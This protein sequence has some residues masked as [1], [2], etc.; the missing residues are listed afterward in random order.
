M[1]VKIDHQAIEVDRLPTLP[2]IA[3]EAIRLMEG[4]Q[5][6]F[7]SIADLLKN[8]QVLTSRILHYANSAYIGSRRISSIS[9]AVSII[10]FNTIRSIILSAS[11]FDF[12]SEKIDGEKEGLVKFWLHSIGVAATAEFLAERLG[13]S[14]P[15]EAYVAGL[16]HDLG[17]LICYTQFPEKF[18]KLCREIDAQGTFSTFGSLPLDIEKNILDTTH[19]EIGKIA[20]NRWQFPEILNKVM[21]LHHQPVVETIEPDAANLPKL[22]RFADVLCVTHNIGSSYF[23]SSETYSHE[24]HHFALERLLLHHHLTTED[25]QQIMSAVYERIKNIGNVLGF[26]D[27]NVYR[28]LVGSANASLGDISLDLEKTNRELTETNRILGAISEM[29]QKLKAGLSLQETAKVVIKAARD[30]F[31]T[32]R[33][34]CIIRNHATDAFIGQSFDNGT[35]HEVHVPTHIST[36]KQYDNEIVSD[37]E[38]EAVQRLERTTLELSKGADF[39]AGI[40]DIVAG[41]K[42]LATFFIADQKSHWQNEPILGELVVDFT[43]PNL[44]EGEGLKNLSENFKAIAVAAG[45][46]IERLLLEACLDRQNQELAEASRKMEESQRQLFHSHRLATVGQLAAGAAHEINNPLTIISLNIQIMERLLE[47]FKNNEE[48]K[49]RLDVIADQEKRISKIIQELMGFARPSQPKFTP[50]SIAEIAQKVLSVINDRVSM[51]KIKIDNRIKDLPPVMVD[52]LQIEQV[53]MNLLINANHAMPDGGKITLSAETRDGFAVTHVTDTGTGIS[54]ENLQRIF[55]PFFT[56]K[57]E[58]EG[59]G[60]GLAVCNSIIEHNGG[61]LRVRSKLKKGTT[62]SFSLPIDKGSRLREMKKALEKNKE[63]KASAA[64]E[65]CRILII[66][67]ERLLNDMLRDSLRKIGYDV[68]GAYDGVEG[69]GLL[70]YK[71]YHLLILDIKMPRK[72]GLDVLQFVREGYPDVKVVIVSGLA[73][74]KEVQETVEMGAFACMKKP[75]RL[76]KIVRIVQEALNSS[77]SSP[78]P[79]QPQ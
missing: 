6:T 66:D 21:W 23:L 9:Q 5:S 12:F 59:T 29:T 20:A 43:D 42:F 48:F 74:K 32:N 37:I 69:I 63:E 19:I 18:A 61:A 45:S 11:I 51:K 72:D 75:F 16:I 35:F 57:M 3:I 47:Q 14:E 7:H 24:H 50:S 53:L 64:L 10:G 54:E 8:D 13:F 79:E 36:A 55:D 52:P 17:K 34:V 73:S 78:N 56:T 38:E 62:F 77:C 15:E 31:G 30:A 26:W 40:M 71:K 22:I 65:N 2:S 44:L 76:G 39:K 41:S 46:A 25:L 1:S 70:R 4:E 27:E 28:K 33:C 67:D 58:G 60:L 49:E 68:D